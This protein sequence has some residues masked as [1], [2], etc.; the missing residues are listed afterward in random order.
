MICAGIG[1]AVYAKDTLLAADGE[2]DVPITGKALEEASRAALAHV[3]EGRVTETEIGDE[4]SY[5]EVEVTLPDGRQ[6]DVQLDEDF[7]VVST[8]ADG[9]E[10][11][12]DD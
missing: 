1:G 4:E 7:R 9:R 8:E 11:G 10:E 3:G 2:G 6:I 5:Y 12:D